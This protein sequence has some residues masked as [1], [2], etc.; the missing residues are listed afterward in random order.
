MEVVRFMTALRGL[1]AAFLRHSSASYTF[2]TP[3]SDPHATYLPLGEMDTVVP[4]RH[5]SSVKQ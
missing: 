4:T 1:G 2:T 3:L 5:P